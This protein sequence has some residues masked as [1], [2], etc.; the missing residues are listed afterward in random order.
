ME[1]RSLNGGQAVLTA[2]VGLAIT[3]LLI[4]L[5]RRRS[6]NRMPPGPWGWP[7]LGCLP[8]L[9]RLPHQTLA[10]FAEKYGPLMSMKL[11]S[12]N[13]VVASSPKMAEEFLKNHDK[14]WASRYAPTGAKIVGYNGSD[15]AFSEY[16]P[17]WRYARKIFMLEL[18]TAKRISVFQAARKEEICGGIND[19]L[20]M[21]QNGKLPVRMDLI[22]GKI[23]GN[24]ITRM[25]MNE[26]S[27]SEK[28]A[29]IKDSHA[30]QQALRDAF[31][32]V[33]NFYLGDYVPWLDRFCSKTQMYAVAKKCDELFQAILDDHKMKL[34]TAPGQSETVTTD[35]NKVQDI[36]DVLLTRP[37]DGDGQYLTEMEMK[38]IILDVLFGGTETNAVTVE[39]GLSELVRNPRVMEKA[40]AEM[41]SMVGKERLVEESDLPNLPYLNAIVKETF[42]LHPIA[43]LLPAHMSMEDCEIQGYKISAKT[44]LLVNIHAIQRDPDVY[45]R[46]LDFYPER[47]LGSEKDVHGLDFDLLPFGSGRRMC[48]GK[49]LGL[50]LVQYTMALFILCCNLKPPGNMKPEELDMEEKF[51]L[52]T[53]RLNCL[54]VV[55][56][57]RLPKSMLR[58]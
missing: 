31:E 27:L 8:R 9:G 26:G 2:L 37:R 32:V 4:A 42:R 56:T 10:K 20:T 33:T 7:V 13:V 16:G 25:L 55:V 18:L 12:A 24:I 51:G 29:R 15:I 44:R 11:G 5:T 43:A 48:P 40:Q 17:R 6:R 34:G 53:P 36:V 45:E 41:D 28:A 3:V 19:A 35:Q 52:S 54:K 14:I 50:V 1:N 21:S 23:A 58:E 57:P 49:G 39:W 46:P 22:L 30:F 38:A 47:F